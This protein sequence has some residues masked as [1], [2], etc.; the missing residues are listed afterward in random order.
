[1]NEGL[2]FLIGFLA[3]LLFFAWMFYVTWKERGDRRFPGYSNPPPMPEESPKEKA[4]RIDEERQEQYSTHTAWRLMSSHEKEQFDKS[5][6]LFDE[7]MTKT[8]K[9]FN[10]T[11]DNFSNK[12]DEIFNTLQK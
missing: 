7:T 11:M 9:E 1:M 2:V 3:F 8:F 6:K 12:M 4:K 5:M 10:A